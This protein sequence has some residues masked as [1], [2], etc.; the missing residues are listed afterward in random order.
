MASSWTAG[1]SVL[2]T[3]ELRDLLHW[4]VLS[5]EIKTDFPLAL[6]GKSGLGV[7]QKNA[8]FT[9]WNNSSVVLYSVK[10]HSLS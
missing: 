8:S 4:G 5:A 2:S 9:V 3:P 6:K 1:S 7:F 10:L